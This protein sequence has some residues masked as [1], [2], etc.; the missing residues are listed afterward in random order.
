MG[1]RGSK[2]ER[3]D[4]CGVHRDLCFC[5][6]LPKLTVAPRI[7]IFLHALEKVRPSNSGSLVAQMVKDTHVVVFGARDSGLA[8]TPAPGRRQLVLDPSGRPLLPDDAHVASELLVAD[9][10]YQQARHMM[11]RIVA[12]RDAEHVSVSPS[13]TSVRRLRKSARPNELSTVEAVAYALGTLGAPAAE[14]ALLD[15]YRIFVE[16]TL[17]RRHPIRR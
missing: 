9:G 6:S 10:T 12:L 17:S 15:A 2:L 7:V 5:G 16:R 1:I 3:C 8:F 4:I 11:Q 14:A 13:R